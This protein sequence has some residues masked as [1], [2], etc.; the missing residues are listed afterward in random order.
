MII[1]LHQNSHC[2]FLLLLHQLKKHQ[3]EI[4]EELYKIYQDSV[5]HAV[6]LGLVE[7]YVYSQEKL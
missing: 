1:I 7:V 3:E 6:G 4:S 2:S 5:L